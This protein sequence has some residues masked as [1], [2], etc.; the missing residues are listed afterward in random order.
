MRRWLVTMGEHFPERLV[1]EGGMADMTTCPGCETPVRVPEG[2][3]GKRAQ[4]PQCQTTFTIPAAGSAAAPAPPVVEFQD[5]DRGI[6]LPARKSIDDEDRARRRQ[7]DW[8][9]D[10]PRP[11]PRERPSSGSALLWALGIAGV[12]L[13]LV[14]FCGGGAVAIAILGWGV[15]APAPGPMA[16]NPVAVA[17][18]PG[19]V[20]APALPGGPGVGL[21]G[22]GPEAVI[23]RAYDGVIKGKVTYDG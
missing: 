1:H 15:H 9:D 23:A 18:P 6:A 17:K 11:H 10:E 20:P 21:G 2:M 14:V 5:L 22:K 4:C 19:G 3:A 13:L 7:R 8:G 12:A 16:G